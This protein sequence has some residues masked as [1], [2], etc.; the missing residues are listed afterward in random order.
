MLDQDKFISIV[1][2]SEVIVAAN[3]TLIGQDKRPSDR[4][5]SFRGIQAT[6]IGYAQAGFVRR[7]SGSQS[8]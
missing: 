8:P 6:G 5:P 2:S 1:E 3:Q 4:D 7:D